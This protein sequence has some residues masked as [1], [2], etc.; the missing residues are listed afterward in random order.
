MERGEIEERYNY[1][2]KIEWIEKKNGILSTSNGMKLNC[3]PCIEF[4]GEKNMLTPTDALLVAINVCIFTTFFEIADKFRIKP[5]S[6]ECKVEGDVD[7]DDNTRFT[8][9]SR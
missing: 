2:T 3:S 8:K 5:K 6:Y 7:V 9:I 4:N 1:E